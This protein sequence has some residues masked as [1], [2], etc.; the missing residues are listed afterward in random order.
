MFFG[1]FKTLDQKI[2]HV[3]NIVDS[4]KSKVVRYPVENDQLA[5]MA[6]AIH[7]Y[8]NRKVANH[9]FN[10]YLERK[11]QEYLDEDMRADGWTIS[12]LST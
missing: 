4:G 11:V 2:E 10:I 9:F 6:E 12:T 8:G 3:I 5:Y 7:R 1:L